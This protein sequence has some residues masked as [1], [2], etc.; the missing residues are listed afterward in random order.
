M[1]LAE[2][3]VRFIEPLKR[4][5]TSM[6]SVALIKA[7]DDSNNFQL[8]KLSVLDGEEQEGIERVQEYGFTSVPPA[9]SEAVVVF[10]GG[11]RSHGLVI[12]T[13]SSRYRLKSLPEGAVALYN[14]N[15]DFVKLTKNKIEISAS[16]VLLAD[17]T[18]KLLTEDI[19]TLLN[20]HVHNCASPGSPSGPALAPS[21]NPFTVALHATSKT[22][23][24]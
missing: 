15:G 23:A 19:I 20:S 17:G 8:L 16:E 24:D 5:L 10:V 12:A 18:K 2:Q 4:K 22:K 9:N 13:E 21:A 11:K 6:I 7:I 14:M 3:L 1:T